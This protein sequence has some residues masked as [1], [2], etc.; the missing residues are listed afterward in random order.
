MQCLARQGTTGGHSRRPDVVRTV[1]ALRTYAVAPRPDETLAGERARCF[2]VLAVR[3]VLPALGTETV[4]CLAED[5][6]P[7]RRRVAGPVRTDEWVA[8]R[9]ERDPPREHYAALLRELALS[10]EALAGGVDE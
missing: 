9:V 7:L 1:V 10:A 3:G 8:V 6:L 4:Y 2:R 5:G